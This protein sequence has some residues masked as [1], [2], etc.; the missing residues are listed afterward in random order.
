MAKKGTW[1]I[2]QENLKKK[3]RRGTWKQGLGSWDQASH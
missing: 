3:K 2:K 1:D